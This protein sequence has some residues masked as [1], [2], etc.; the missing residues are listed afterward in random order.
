MIKNRYISF[1]FRCYY[2]WNR[3]NESLPKVCPNCKSKYW[4]RPRKILSRQLV[5]K[6]TETITHIHDAIIN[7]SGGIKGIRDEGGVYNSTYKLLHYQNKYKKNPIDLGAFILDEFAKR[8]HFV[9]GNKRTAYAAAKIFMLVNRCHLQIEYPEAV[10]FI[11]E[12][13]KYKSKINI[14]NIKA[15]LDNNCMIIEEKDIEKYLKNVLVN[16]ILE[17]GEE[18]ERKQ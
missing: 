7:L 11:L 9:D 10:K 18:N 4:N 5:L 17:V 8:H 12:I 6:M 2:T 1:C 3:R 16:I 15:W 14:E 13:A